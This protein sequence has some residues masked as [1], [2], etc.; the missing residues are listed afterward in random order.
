MFKSV[1]AL[2][3]LAV[4]AQA[5]PGFDSYD[6]APGSV[7]SASSTYQSANCA[8]NRCLPS[9]VLDPTPAD[10]NDVKTEQW[11]SDVKACNSSRSESLSFDWSK[12][13]STRLLSE[14]RFRYGDIE[15]DGVGLVLYSEIPMN[16]P[17]PTAV[18][19]EDSS[20]W[21]VFVFNE[22]VTASGMQLTWSNLKSK[23]GGKNCYVAI[24]EVQAWTGPPPSGNA[25]G[26]QSGSG[27]NDPPAPAPP[28][29]GLS[30]GAIAAIVIVPI[31]ALVVI[32]G[33]YLA[34]TRRTNLLKSRLAREVE[35]SRRQ[36]PEE[37]PAAPASP[38]SPNKTLS[39]QDKELL[40]RF[41]KGERCCR[42][43]LRQRCVNSS[44]HHSFFRTL[45]A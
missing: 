10:S 8:G 32:A 26:N 35:L 7:V 34:R 17:N 28:K 30:S 15:A 24:N 40:R 36:I 3:A 18:T 27:Q 43:Y 25:G 23:D 9:N 6:I 2:A 37:A 14:I 44:I 1:I 38:S 19:F 20:E 33:I 5:A 4:V 12:K 42:A 39:A 13:Y 22:P 16:V 11:V 41:G 31:A 21:T 45:S 29:A